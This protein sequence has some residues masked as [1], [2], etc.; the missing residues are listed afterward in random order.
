MS[1][2]YILKFLNKF[3]DTIL[4]KKPKIDYNISSNKHVLRG[5]YYFSFSKSIVEQAIKNPDIA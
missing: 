2:N 3:K 5:E 1:F 4:R